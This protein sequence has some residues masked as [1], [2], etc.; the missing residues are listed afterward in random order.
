[1]R[2]E[3]EVD[4]ALSSK[5]ALEGFTKCVARETNPKW[6]IKFLILSPGGVKTNFASSITYLPRHP[7]YANDPEAPLNPFI[8]YL[9]DPTLP[10][11]WADPDKCAA[12]L[13]DAVVG[14]KQRSLPVRLK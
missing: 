1:M 14:Q 5:F 4:H 6:N 2:Q 13:F 7:A 3:A 10:D 12:V 11:S 9:E 8:K